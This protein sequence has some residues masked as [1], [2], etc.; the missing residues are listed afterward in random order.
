M[1]SR[2]KHTFLVYCTS[3]KQQHKMIQQKCPECDGRGGWIPMPASDAV[4][5]QCMS[6]TYRCEGCEAYREHQG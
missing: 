2:R 3:C 5:N 6:L 1:A 4:V